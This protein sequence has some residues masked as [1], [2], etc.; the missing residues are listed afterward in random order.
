[1][2]KYKSGRLTLPIDKMDDEKILE[3][4]NLWGADAIRD[5]DGTKLSNELLSQFDK[6]YS[7]YLTTRANIKWGEDHPEELSQIYLMTD[8]HTATSNQLE[9]YLLDGY[10]EEEIQVNKIADP[11]RWWEVIDR[12]TGEVVTADNWVF[13]SNRDTVVIQ[14][15][16]WH[17]YTVTYLAFQIWD[18]VCMYNHLTNDWGDKPHDLPY[19][20]YNPKTKQQ[21]MEFLKDFLENNPQTDVVR[22]TTFFYQF[23]LVYNDR[24]EEKIV[25]WFGYSGS[26]NPR[27]LEDFEKEYVYRLRPEDIVDQGYHNNSF[28]IPS[29]K[30]L[31]YIDFVS[32]FV[33]NT[34]KECVALAHE[35]GKEAMMFLG[36][37]WIGTEPFGDTFRDIGLDAVVGSVG[38]GVTCR[39]IAEIPHVKYRE[40]RFL[41]YFFPDTFYE[42]GE[43][44]K[45]ANENWLAAR[46]SICRK[47]L[48]RIGYGGYLGLAAQFP[49]FIERVSEIADEFREIADKINHTAP[50]TPKVKVAIL[51]CWGDKR[52]WQ[53][54]MIAH[55]KIYKQFNHYIGIIEA[56]CGA[57]LE[58]EFISFEDIIE[59]GID[60]DIKVIINYGDE[61]TAWSGGE[62]WLNDKVLK[63]VREFVYNGGGLIGVG[64]PSAIV[65]QG[66]F[67]QLA[68]IFGVDE[69][70]SL[71]LIN[72]KYNEEIQ[73]E[74][75][76]LEGL[77]KEIDFGFGTDNVYQ[78]SKTTK[79]LITRNGCT[80][81][82]VNTF[83][84]GRSV[85]I[86]GLPYNAAN[87]RLLLRSVYYAGGIEEEL[88]K[89]WFSEN[90]DTE[91]NAYPDAGWYCVLNNSYQTQD[92]IIYKGNGEK[93][94]L[95]LQPME[96]KWISI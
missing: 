36:D 3:I 43:P 7:T 90:V 57:A 94:D 10:Y 11:Y 47:P 62:Y 5:S 14:A 34:A 54:T 35:Y 1:M 86:A 66:R 74:H 67:F 31:D 19:D 83:G 72:T 48:D 52:R 20:V 73:E 53:A 26:V 89:S 76:I 42:G 22:F 15:E 29:R 77:S 37:H 51:N 92:T 40:G 79:N 24:K 59:K 2:A 64:E 68:D 78:V 44:T 56:L 80:K 84:K 38:D 6:V 75:F 69:E 88:K 4:K 33:S 96:I 49:D 39:M 27:L 17:S 41:P 16:P 30:Y 9:I 13:D 63:C 58:V 85:Y 91:C 18:A 46:R 32:K 8:F 61:G 25:D 45:E 50:Y 70:R 81:L 65:H 95:T 87:T 82:A 23:T 71:S 21:V 55:A 28:R 60:E 93:V 12:T